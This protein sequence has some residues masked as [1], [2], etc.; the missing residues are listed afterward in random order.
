MICNKKNA[1]RAFWNEPFPAFAK[2]AEF[3]QMG[4]QPDSSGLRFLPWFFVIRIHGSSWK[5]AF[6]RYSSV[7]PLVDDK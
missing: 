3:F 5:T 1:L 7:E 6:R 4:L 2:E